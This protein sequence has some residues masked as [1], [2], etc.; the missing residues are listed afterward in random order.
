MGGVENP[1]CNFAHLDFM[2]TMCP[3]HNSNDIVAGVDHLEGAIVHLGDLLAG[4]AEI[5]EGLGFTWTSL[6]IGFNQAGREDS[7]NRCRMQIAPCSI[8]VAHFGPLDQLLQD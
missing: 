8:C 7:S 1:C 6:E 3:L 4:H 2:H 5:I